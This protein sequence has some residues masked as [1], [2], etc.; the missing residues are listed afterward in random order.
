LW[1][2]FGLPWA[3]GS[4]AWLA[5]DPTVAAHLP[6]VMTD[7]PLGLT[8]LIA[9]V[10][11][12]LLATR[13]QWRW[14]AGLGL[15]I[16]LALGAK[17]SALPGIVGIVSVA[18]LA[19]I[20]S[21]RRGTVREVLGRIGKLALAG[22]LGIVVLWAQYGFQFH[23]GP[24]GHDGFNRAMSGKIADLN[25]AHWRQ[26]IAIAD[27]FHLLPRSYLWG[28]A[29]TVRTGVEGRGISE[30]LVWGRMYAGRAP[31]FSWPLIVL[32]KVPL[33]LL[34]LSVLGTCLLWRVPLPR[35]ARCVLWSVCGSA[36]AYLA[37]LL[38]SEGIWG[39]IRHAMP[40]LVGLC[41][42]AGAAVAW[43]WRARSQAAGIRLLAVAALLLAA[44]VMTIGERRAW[45]Y[46]NELVGGSDGA[47]R[48]FGNEGLDLGQRFSELRAFHDRVIQPSGERLY[49]NYWVGEEQMRAARFNYRRRV[50]SLD[51][52]NVEGIYQG[53]YIYT[54]PD[55]RPQ[56]AWDWDPEVVFHGL[57]RVAQ[58]GFAEV[59]H[60]R[61]V[62]PRTRASSMA[63]KVFD[64]IYKDNGNDWALVARRLEEVAAFFPQ[65]AS[66]GI[67][68]GNAYVRLGDGPMAI[69][70]YRRPLGQTKAPVDARIRA[71]VE[72]RIVAIERGADLSTLAPLRNPEME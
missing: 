17:H 46:H 41:I 12:G 31:W 5:I 2:A 61:Q 26:G 72:A 38:G 13:W 7:L 23:S 48:Y 32:S 47:W 53:Y 25:L 18:A 36:L 70:A 9:A 28:L 35:D 20:G 10:C 40:L 27:R 29:D 4:L 64:Y 15:A 6:V 69:R 50:E 3:V 42:P 24:D 60:G 39:G 59:W 65:S 45:E 43:A 57:E 14:V 55:H 22:V 56:P 62:L 51:D 11:A 68:L 21:W 30:H 49:S 37:A 33:P 52:T 63:S 34:L 8:L 19:A 54:R 1:R 58:F 16:G 71:Q 44:A 67:E 66:L